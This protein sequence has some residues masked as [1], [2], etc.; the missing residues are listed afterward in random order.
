MK[1]FLA[2]FAFVA[3][4]LSASTQLKAQEVSAMTGS[5]VDSSG[6]VL[7]GVTVTLINKARGLTYTQTTNAGGSYRFSS[8]PPGPGYEANFMISGFAP[9]TVKDISL[10]VATIRTQDATLIAGMHAEVE[11]NASNATVTINTTDATIGN[12]FDVKQLN[13]LPVQQRNDPTALFTLQPGV[14][15]TASVTGARSDQNNVTL[16]GLDVNDLATGGST[17]NNSGITQQFVIV[18]HAPVDSVQEFRATVG[19]LTADSGPSSGGQFQ[20]VTK[21]G[22]NAFHGNINEYHRDPS[23]VANSWFNNNASP[24]VPRNHLIQNQFGGNIGGPIL[25]DKLFFFFNYDNSR[26]IA[27]Q[28]TTRTVPL[29]S[30]RAGNI[31]YLNNSDSGALS[32]INQAQ[33][34]ALDPR[35]VGVDATWLAAMNARFPVSNAPGGDGINSGGYTFNAPDNDFETNYVSRVDYN[36]TD[37]M[38]MFARF[39]I[40]R[41]NAVNP[42]IV[43]QFLADPGVTSPFVDRTYA[44]VIGHNWQIGA[45]KVNQFFLGT[46]V[47]KYNY[48][49]NPNNFN[50]SGNN[51]G[52]ASWYT[53]GDGTG[54]SLTS[55]LTLQPNAQS[56]RVPIP[57]VG[58][59]FTWLKGS[60]TWQVG[61][62]FKD[63]LARNTNVADY[64]SVQL[65]MGGHVFALCGPTAKECNANGALP[66]PDNA[67]LRPSDLDEKGPNLGGT[68]VYTY[69]S[70]FALLLGRVGQVSSDY[71]YSK[72]GAALPQL[73]GDTRAYR[74]YQTQIY[75]ADTWKVT[76]SLTLSYGVNYQYFSVP[77]EVNGYESV[78]QVTYNQYMSA[79]VKQ[80]AAS[81]SGPTAVPLITYSLGGKA[82]NG[83][84]LYQP[85]HH[86]FAP[87]FGFAFNPG[88]D[89][90]TV[91]NGSAGMVY[92][93]TIINAVQFIQD[94]DS[95]LFQLTNPIDSGNSADP[96]DSILN[97]PRLD[98]KNG[99][100]N[101][102]GIAAPAP[103]KSPYSPFNSA[104]QCGSNPTPCGLALGSAF[105]ATIDPSLKTPYSFAINFGMQTAL[106]GDFVLKMSYAGRL[107][108]RLLAQADAN[109][110]LDF[111]DPASGQLYSQAV[112]NVTKQLRAGVAATNITTQPWFENQ[113]SGYGAP[114]SI[115]QNLANN[116][117]LGPFLFR[118]DIGDFTQGIS[119]NIAQNIGSSAQFSENGF[120]TNKGSSSYNALLLTLQKNFSHGLQFDFNYTFAHSIDNTSFFA[121]SEGDTGIG[122]VGLV[123]DD[124]RPRE[125]RSNSDFDMTHYI[126]ADFTYQL[127]FG[128]H[129]MFL[130]SSPVWVNEVVGGWDISGI[131]DW[132]TGQAWGTVSNAFDASFSNDAPAILV[133]P[134]SAVAT[135]LT[136]VSGSNPNVFSDSTA[137]SN[138]YI[139]PI[140][141]QIGARNGLR[142]PKYFNEDL[143]L[144]KTF[145]IYGDRINVKFRADAFNAFN[146]PNFALPIENG[147]NG[148]DNQDVTNP[149]FGQITNTVTPPGQLNNGARVLQLSLRVEF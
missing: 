108:R 65:G 57:V 62:T 129:R 70:A 42:G 45:N 148:F 35:G 101:V 130:G 54:P 8:I 67:S 144:A 4:L 80:S 26:I 98:S 31:Q 107:G 127:P 40:S 28:S 88:W 51:G 135:H 124:I 110:V 104:A 29:N 44:F 5:V 23:L 102:P 120:Y 33:I 11:V 85:E 103:P 37:K 30:L 139:G 84:P 63:I 18:G 111:P 69:D 137:A 145:P 47:Q 49:I 96:Y 94:Q 115:T 52:A 114:G 36:L 140:G 95:Y 134:R 16:D 143:G 113:V 87:R 93:R 122:G 125:C 46:T 131:T 123:C 109:Q 27:A 9:L 92:D 39:T 21:S 141:F 112:G 89:K 14:T 20:L 72:A 48:P 53:T 71:N 82:N 91:F 97:D 74:Y 10:N 25:K 56:R 126:T 15:D 138:A 76:P 77:Y 133:G 90:K 7:P 19:G 117:N 136:K 13:N 121:N 43:N 78:E 75:A 149:D 3:I 147:F 100:S 142:G 99:L 83:P 118:G 105:N 106:P 58:D 73:T 41:E 34:A 119:T 2:F 66:L 64:N 128:R 24:V 116:S 32:Q 81:M 50:S 61:G 79:R 6:A 1:K 55:S 146:H 68:A 38:K 17:Q 60:H 86:L 59:N 12:I 132:H 22:T